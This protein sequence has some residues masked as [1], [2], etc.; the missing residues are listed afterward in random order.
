MKYNGFSFASSKYLYMR[1]TSS[2]LDLTRMP[3]SICR[4]ILLKKLSIILSHE[5]CFGVNTNSNRPGTVARYLLVS[6]DV[7]TLRLSSTMRILSPFGYFSSSSCK[8]SIYSLLLCLSLMSGILSP[9]WRSIAARSD[10]VPN[11][12]Y[13]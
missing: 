13:S 4:V 12:L 11:L 2:S 7:C 9:V 10:I 1:F 6:S 3:R 8:N 5:P